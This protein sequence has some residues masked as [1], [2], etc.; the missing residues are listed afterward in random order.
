MKGTMRSKTIGTIFATLVAAASA[1][2]GDFAQAADNGFRTAPHL[3]GIQAL[4]AFGLAIVGTAAV[5]MKW[6]KAKLPV[7]T[8]TTIAATILALH[9]GDFANAADRGFGLDRRSRTVESAANGVAALDRYLRTDPLGALQ[10]VARFG[11][12]SSYPR[13]IAGDYLSAAS[14]ERGGPMWGDLVFSSP[15]MRAVATGSVGGQG[16]PVGIGVASTGGFALAAPVKQ[17]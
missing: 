15:I 8:G 16:G 11:S 3:T 12:D 13:Q 1:H 5:L 14:R 7:L 4:L 2:A 9:A 10:G 6:H 17:Q